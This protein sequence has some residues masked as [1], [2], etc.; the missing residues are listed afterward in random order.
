MK[1]GRAVAVSLVLAA[2]S[3][4]THDV[5]DYDQIIER[6]SVVGGDV[7]CDSPTSQGW[8][9]EGGPYVSGFCEF[10][11]VSYGTADYVSARVDFTRP[12]AASPWSVAF[13]TNVPGNC[14]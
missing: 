12:D 8:S 10:A 9:P 4:E 2:C 3:N 13:G 5:A 1:Y 11:C 7:T 6:Y 14:R